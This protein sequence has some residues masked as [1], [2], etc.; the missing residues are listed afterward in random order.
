M[1]CPGVLEVCLVLGGEAGQAQVAKLVL[2]P[3]RT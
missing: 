2:A 3:R 1:L